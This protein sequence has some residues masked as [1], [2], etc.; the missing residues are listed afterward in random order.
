[1]A[2]DPLQSAKRRLARAQTHIAHLEAGA[3]LFFDKKPTAVATEQ[4][5]QG[6]TVVTIVLT[7]PFPEQLTD[8]A[9]EAVEALRSVLDQMAFAIAAAVG[10]PDSKSAHFPIADDAAGLETG[11]KGRCKDIPQEVIT[12][13]RSFKPYKG[14]NDLKNPLIL[15]IPNEINE[16]RSY[17]VQDVTC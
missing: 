10:K 17:C 7:E 14:G 12:F 6:N 13:F 15:I 5:A 1:M 11:I 8:L 2:V 3:K 9:V 4:D 16:L